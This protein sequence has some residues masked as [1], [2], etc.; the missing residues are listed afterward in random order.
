MIRGAEVL[1]IKARREDHREGDLRVLLRGRTVCAQAILIAGRGATT[2]TG[3][4]RICSVVRKAVAQGLDLFRKAL[5]QTKSIWSTGRQA[6]PL[7][8]LRGYSSGPWANTCSLHHDTRNRQPISL[9]KQPDQMLPRRFES[10]SVTMLAWVVHYV[11]HCESTSH[12]PRLRSFL[13]S[14]R[15]LCCPSS[16]PWVSIALCYFH[17]LT[18]FLCSCNAFVL[19]NTGSRGPLILT[20]SSPHRRFRSITFTN[21]IRWTDLQTPKYTHCHRYG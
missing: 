12:I 14:D 10:N 13:L 15:F 18:S 3:A 17:D 9:P 6:L 16:P 8:V 21:H 7:L 2:A 5:L 19:D 4:M 1:A 20:S 11:V